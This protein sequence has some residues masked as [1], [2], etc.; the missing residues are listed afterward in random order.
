MYLAQKINYVEPTKFQ[1]DS[2]H[3]LL[4]QSKTKTVTHIFLNDKK[5]SI[6][7]SFNYLVV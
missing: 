3:F 1:E 6:N 5:W 2:S 7:L 4:L